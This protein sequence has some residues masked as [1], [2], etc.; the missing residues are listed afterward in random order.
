MSLVTHKQDESVFPKLKWKELSSYKRLS[1]PHTVSVYK[2]KLLQHKRNRSCLK[3]KRKQRQ[4]ERKI[5]NQ[6][7]EVITSLKLNDD[8]LLERNKENNLGK[9]LTCGIDNGDVKI[10][11]LFQ[12]NEKLYAKVEMKKSVGG[13]VVTNENIVLTNELYEKSLGKLLEYY[14]ERIT[15]H[16]ILNEKPV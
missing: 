7:N 16:N 4:S 3:G 13:R 12:S 14:E 11:E 6:I 8:D 9:E 15:K 10:K 1:A 5:K 2:G